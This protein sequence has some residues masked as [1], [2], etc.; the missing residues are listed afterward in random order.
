MEELKVILKWILVILFFPISL[1]FLAYFKQKKANRE[2]YN[3]K[4]EWD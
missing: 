2:L 4:E 3:S 1:L